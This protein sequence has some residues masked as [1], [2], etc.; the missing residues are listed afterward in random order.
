MITAPPTTP[1]PPRTR[2]A[3]WPFSTAPTDHSRP[4]PN[5]TCPAPLRHRETGSATPA[6]SPALRA[7]LRVGRAFAVS[8]YL[9][10]VA[11]GVAQRI[12]ME[13]S[14]CLDFSPARGDRVP[15]ELG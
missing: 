7:G 3:P 14:L 2:F 11:E 13:Q 10:G 8:P 15:H 4:R 5:F 1:T 6:P 12:G 9:V